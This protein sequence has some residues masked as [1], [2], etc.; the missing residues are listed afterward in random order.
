MTY[1]NFSMTF[2]EEVYDLLPRKSPKNQGF[3]PPVIKRVIK[4]SNQVSNQAI[5][6]GRG[7]R[8]MPF[9]KG[10]RSGFPKL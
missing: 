9:E 4:K 5:N 1:W 7:L 10:S 3:S 8:S 2:A 6:Q